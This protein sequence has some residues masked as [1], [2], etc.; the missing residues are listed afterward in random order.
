M[1]TSPEQ[2]GVCISKACCTPGIAGIKAHHACPG[3][4][5]EVTIRAPQVICCWGG[6]W[7][8]LQTFVVATTQKVL[9][10]R[11]NGGQG[12]AQDGLGMSLSPH[13]GKRRQPSRPW[14]LRAKSLQSCPTLCDPMA[15]SPASSS[16]CGVLQARILEWVA[17]PSF[18]GSSPPR[19]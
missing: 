8:H 2:Q 1:L 7:Q 15:H 6:L 18:R 3:F 17:R 5:M 14:V 4:L 16:V 10:A 11:R 19:N 9:P 12:N 13:L